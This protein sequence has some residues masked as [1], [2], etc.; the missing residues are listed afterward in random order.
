MKRLLIVA[1]AAMV[2][3]P[4]Q[5]FWGMGD[6]TFDPTT[7]GEVAK[8]YQQAVELYKTAKQQLDNLASIE[9]TIK[10]AQQAYDTLGSTR[11]RTV[12]AGLRDTPNT[13]SA[14]ELRAALANAESGTSQS[15]SY[16]QYQLSQIQQLENLELLKKASADNAEQATHKPNAATSAAISA[17]S[18][19]TLAALAAV[20]EQR[21]VKEDME[22]AAAARTQINILK[23]TGK[24]YEAMGK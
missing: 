14:A 15:A 17:Q 20:E 23:D 18:E 21:R 22:R 5:A 19:A 11:L 4:A 13:K 10:D 3:H 24:V 6:I 1:I 9:K 8:Q 2:T 7:Y 12:T 16:L